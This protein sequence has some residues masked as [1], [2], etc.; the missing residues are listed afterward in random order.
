MRAAA[1]VINADRAANVL[2]L[3]VMLAWSFPNERAARISRGG[4]SGEQIRPTRFF[5]AERFGWA[6]ERDI[7]KM[8]NA[9][10]RKC[11]ANANTLVSAR[12]SDKV[13]RSR[14]LRFFLSMAVVAGEEERVREC[15]CSVVE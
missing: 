7:M 13:L 3:R 15:V 9:Q 1:P 11:N 4:Q 2:Y 14:I 6:R 8:M 12:V 10:T 5:V